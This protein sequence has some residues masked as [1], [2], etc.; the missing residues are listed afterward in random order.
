MTLYTVDLAGK[1]RGWSI[2]SEFFFRWLRN[3][4]GTGT[5]PHKSL[6]QRGFYVEGGK[7]LIAKKLDI[8]AR[9]SQIDGHFG[10]SSEYGAGINYFPFDTHLVKVS[11]DVSVLDSSPLLN[12]SPN[13]H[14]CDLRDT[15]RQPAI[16]QHLSVQNSA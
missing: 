5:L 11:F 3:I 6:F 16:P 1:Y 9:Y 4:A 8:N 14:D 2:N 15:S 13:I 7:F 10:N 12:V